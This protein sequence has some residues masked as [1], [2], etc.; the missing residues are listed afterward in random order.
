[1]LARWEKPFLTTFSD[2]DPITRVAER[3]FQREVPG[4]RGEPHIRPHAG[5]FLQEDAAP[6]LAQAINHLIARG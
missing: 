4:A 6:E 1:V 3:G 2:G 5:H